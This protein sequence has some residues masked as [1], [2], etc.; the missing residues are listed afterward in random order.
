MEDLV[1]QIRKL[2]WHLHEQRTVSR[3]AFNFQAY[4]DLLE[5]LNADCLMISLSQLV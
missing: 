2:V 1:Q 4:N 3:I 5:I